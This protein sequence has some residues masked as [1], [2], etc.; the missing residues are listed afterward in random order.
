MAG[1]VLTG[2]EREL[3][4]K[5]LM[6]GNVPVTIMPAA[7][8]QDG[9]HADGVRAVGAVFPVAVK[10]EQLKVLDSG[11]ILLQNPAPAVRTFLGR[12]VTVEFF[13]NK[14][15]LCF[16]TELKQVSA[17][18]ALVVP[19]MI[20][21]ITEVP[22]SRAKGFSATVF[23]SGGEPAAGSVCCMPAPGFSVFAEPSW[24]DIPHEVAATAKEYLDC[25]MRQKPQDNLPVFSNALYLVPACRYLAQNSAGAKPSV[26]CV[27]HEY[28]VFGSAGDG[29]FLR[30][31]VEYAVKLSFPLPDAPCTMYR[32]VYGFCY[33]RRRL[34]VDGVPL[35]C[36]VC[37]FAAVKEEDV[38][39]MQELSKWAMS[40]KQ[41]AAIS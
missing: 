17:G 6:D 31:G 41:Q 19:A 9:T 38:R 37:S 23:Y 30:E 24:N 10:P 1:A 26:L 21:R 28:I 33:V 39:F 35:S 2:I 32:E 27:T 40:I 14:L 11:I 13:F 34:C 18:L 36:T 5:Y 22:D 15:G 29:S 16:T 3:V 25:F 7:Q 4:L 8:K 12:P 20:S